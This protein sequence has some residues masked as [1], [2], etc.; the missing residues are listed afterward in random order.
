[1][2]RVQEYKVRIPK[3]VNGFFI[4]DSPPLE[5]IWILR[6]KTERKYVGLKYAVQEWRIHGLIN[7]LISMSF[8][9]M[10]LTLAVTI[11]FDSITISF[12]IEPF[13]VLVDVKIEMT[14]CLWQSAHLCLSRQAS[15]LRM[16][17]F[18]RS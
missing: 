8:K 16:N 6:A 9:G 12:P 7:V 1:M 14:L 13:L 2:C 17:H 5:K 11:P 3:T 4:P 15:T 10:Q 18:N